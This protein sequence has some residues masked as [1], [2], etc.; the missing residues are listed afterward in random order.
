MRKVKSSFFLIGSIAVLA[1]CGGISLFLAASGYESLYN[2][3][4][5]LV[6]TIDE[7]NLSA[8]D[9]S[10]DLHEAIVKDDDAV[11]YG[12]YGKPLTV[13]L[14]QREARLDVV[15]PLQE[16]STWLSRA[17]ALH[18]LAPE[19]PRNGAMGVA[20]MY[21]RAGFRTVTTGTLPKA[22][23]NIF[24]DTDHSW[25]YVYKITSTAVSS[26]SMPYVVAD[27]GDTSK[28]LIV[29]YD[30]SSKNNIYIEAALLSVQGIDS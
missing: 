13:K 4:L 15:K 10:Y 18:L 2:R 23:S 21:C 28:L 30:E 22:G 7:V 19:S 11:V 8:F 27:G 25:R 24:M 12:N 17:S 9:T 14:P 1:V 5:P 16:G 6:H 29:C 26:A 3:S 20:F